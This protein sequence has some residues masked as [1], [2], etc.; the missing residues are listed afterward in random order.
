L[1][2]TLRPRQLFDGFVLRISCWFLRPRSP[3]PLAEFGVFHWEDLM[4]YELPTWHR[5]AAFKQVWRPLWPPQDD[6]ALRERQHALA[7]LLH[8]PGHVLRCQLFGRLA[9]QTSG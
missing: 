4:P 8:A 1:L 2:H 7:R 3:A 5:L 9:D 6:R